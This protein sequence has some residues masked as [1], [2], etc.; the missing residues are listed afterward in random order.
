MIRASLAP[1]L[2]ALFVASSV[3][4]QA[5]PQNYPTQG[6]GT[7]VLHAA[8]LIDGTGAAP[9]ENGVVVVTGDRI[10]AAGRRGSVAEPPA[11]RVP[12]S[13]TAPTVCRR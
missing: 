11:I 12:P 2:A 7:V 3:A 10:V 6:T 13:T 8:R 4:A 1:A 5:R 9:I